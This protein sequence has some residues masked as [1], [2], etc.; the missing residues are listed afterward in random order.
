MSG[1]NEAAWFS[2]LTGAAVKSMAVLAAA[3]FAAAMLRGRSA[4]VRHLA[5]TAAFVAILVLPFLSAALPALRIPL[6]SAMLPAGNAVF[7]ATIEGAADAGVTHSGVPGG[8][9]ASLGRAG[10]RP[11][12]RMWLM[13]L[14]AAGAAMALARLAAGSAAA[15]RVRRSA[16][17]L[18]DGDLCGT[19]AQRLGIRHPV[20]LLQI[21]PGSM[22]MAFGLRRA[23]ILM[24]ADAALWSA[25]RRRTVLLHELA[26]VRRN[27][28]ATHLLARIAMAFYWWN[29]LAWFGWRAFLKERERA[30]DDLVLNAGARASEYA[31]HLLEVARSMRTPPAI[32]WA[33]AAMARRSQLE[34]RL[35]AILDSGVDRTAPSHG[36]VLAA[37]LFAAVMILPLAAVRAQDSGT[38][39]IPADI[40]A[41]IRVA[42]SQK[43]YETLEA[44][45]QAATQSKKYDA[46]RKLLEAAVAIRAQT[47]GEQSV[48]YAVGLVKLAELEQKR[49][50]TAGGELFAKA[51]QIL[52]Q[53]P[54]AAPALTHLGL[55]ALAKKDYA[56]AFAYF[57]RAQLVDP[58]N[59]GTALMWMA[60]VRQQE[61]NIDEAE[62]LYQSALAAKDT[63]PADAAVIM[64]VYSAFLRKQDRADEAKQFEARAG[65]IQKASAKPSPALPAGVFRMG[66]SVTPPVPV[67]RPEPEYTEE[68]RLAMLQGTVVVQVVIGIDGLAHDARIMRELGLG[69][70]ENALEAISQWQFKPGVKDG[71]PVPVAATIEVN[72]RLM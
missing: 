39:A 25:E 55:A 26:H 14:W 9:V 6:A 34:G 13:L 27:E 1:W 3:C 56:Q 5:W 17:P 4:A 30:A 44:A 72:F 29:P 40:D 48:E 70:D 32:A 50:R 23:A 69:L 68:A 10:W 59:A 54:E 18:P 11:D 19:L 37:A 66:K 15:W 45:A 22:P 28:A 43:N 41:A 49:D 7:Q 31:S 61:K 16:R 58:A 60:V 51:A 46:A 24:P 36:A 63:K 52:G 67:R 42:Q 12:W 2:I 21:G 35:L 38:R 8:A 20:D 53:R 71:Q 57:E 62:R 47:A 33:A 64:R 65:D